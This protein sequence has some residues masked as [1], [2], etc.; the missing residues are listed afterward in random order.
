MGER[1]RVA[2]K[3]AVRRSRSRLTSKM[4]LRDA[5]QGWVILPGR[6]SNSTSQLSGAS[7]S[8]S[9]GCCPKNSIDRKAP[10]QE[11]G[12]VVCVGIRQGGTDPPC[13]RTPRRPSCRPGQTPSMGLVGVLFRARNVRPD[14]D[15]STIHPPIRLEEVNHDQ[16]QAASPFFNSLLGAIRPISGAQGSRVPSPSPCRSPTGS[17][18]LR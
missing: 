6:P 14:L 1:F 18:A 12:K 9:V 11:P 16:I 13:P 4:R 2:P 3:E 15:C 10:F 5:G 7:R 17:S 8:W